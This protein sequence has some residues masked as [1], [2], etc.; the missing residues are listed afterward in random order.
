M[1]SAYARPDG[2]EVADLICDLTDV[3]YEQY[4]QGCYGD[5]RRAGIRVLPTAVVRF[6]QPDP[7]ADLH[8]DVVVADEHGVLPETYLAAGKGEGTRLRGLLTSAFEAAL[9]PFGPV[10]NVE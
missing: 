1:L 5:F 7:H 10:R 4:R 8:F 2:A 3:P 9:A 6:G